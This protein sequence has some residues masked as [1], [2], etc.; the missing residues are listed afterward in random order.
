MHVAGQ[1]APS[2]PDKEEAQKLLE[3]ASKGGY[4]LRTRLDVD[5]NVDVKSVVIPFEVAKRVFGKHVAE[6]H[7]VVQLA[8][9]NSSPT[10]AF[11][12]HSAYIDFSNFGQVPTTG[13]A[14]LL[15]GAAVSG[16]GRAGSATSQISSV[17]GR[18]ARGQLLD[19]QLTTGRNITMRVLTTLGSV[20]AGYSFSFAEVGIAKGIA[21]FNGNVVPGM[22]AA[23]PDSTVA[24]LN[25]ISDFGYQTNKL[26]PR[27]AADIVVCFFPIA[28]F[29]TPGFQNV[30]RK[31][32]AILFTPLQV[33]ND[34]TVNKLLAQ[35]LV[36]NQEQLNQAKEVLPCFQLLRTVLQIQPDAEKASRVSSLG[37]TS[38][39]LQK[40][41]LQECWGTLENNPKGLSQLLFLQSL[42]FDNILIKIDGAMAVDT[43]EVPARIGEVKFEGDEKSPVFW[44]ELGVKKAEIDGSYLSNGIVKILED[45]ELGIAEVAVDHENST[46]KSLK[47]SFKTSKPIASGTKLSFVVERKYKADAKTE[48]VIE[49]Q[50]FEYVVGYVMVGP[51]VTKVKQEASTVTAEGANFLDLPPDNPFK[52][53]LNN[54][55]NAQGKTIPVTPKTRTEKQFSFDVPDDAPSGCWALRVSVGVMAAVDVTTKI[56]KLPDSKLK[57][58]PKLEGNTLTA[59]GDELIDTADCGGALEFRAK[60]ASGATIVLKPKTLEIKKV[61]FEL[62]EELRKVKWT[63][64]LW[65]GKREMKPALAITP[66]A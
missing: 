41:L 64:E 65:Q 59:G 10:A 28:N 24:Q 1:S 18:V 22:A 15:G 30:F 23:W 38:A 31:A 3:E 56:A 32:P 35:N 29:L 8:I 48:S 47:F 42:S 58:E 62:P 20:A 17:E 16:P 9:S 54:N 37:G 61:V 63:L 27:Q 11:I 60:T 14:A 50:K 36:L 51:S 33:L 19:A 13:F 49:S 52:V 7:I 46:D 4:K 45:K 21:A 25:R 2:A 12:L 6:R 55:P 43:R 40:R 57:G 66:P 5:S 39:D 53:S 44:A 26:V 34:K